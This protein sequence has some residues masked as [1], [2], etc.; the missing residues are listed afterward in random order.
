[1]QVSGRPIKFVG[2]GERLEDLELFYPEFLIAWHN[3]FRK[4]LLPYTIPLNRSTVVLS[5]FFNFYYR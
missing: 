1:M 2:L 5:V 3:E 4:G